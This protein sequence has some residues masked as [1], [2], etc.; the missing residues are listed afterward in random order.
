MTTYVE[1][2]VILTPEFRVGMAHV[3][4]PYLSKDAK[5]GDKPAYLVRA[6]FPHPS[7]MAPAYAKEYA[8]FVAKTKAACQ[9]A[10][11]EKFGPE[12]AKW[13]ANLRT[14]F[15]DQGEKDFDGWEAGAMWMTLS[16]KKQAPQIINAANDDIIDESQ[17]YSGCYA[18]ATFH[19]YAY[20]KSGNNG[21]SVD[22]HNLQKL[23]DGEPLGSVRARAQDEFEPVVTA[24]TQAPVGD[25]GAMDLLS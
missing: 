8:A 5:P 20:S 24:E 9:K 10:L 2:E 17:F 3:F 15:R 11:V 1:Q 22:L 6:L 23:R 13:P 21:V 19:V 4:K 12:K 16:N 18:R 7:K 14:P 25:G